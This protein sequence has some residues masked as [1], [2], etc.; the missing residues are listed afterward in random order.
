MRLE[1]KNMQHYLAQCT[2]CM[3]VDRWNR[4]YFALLW[5]CRKRTRSI[6]KLCCVWILKALQM[7]QKRVRQRNAMNAGCMRRKVP[8]C[9]PRQFWLLSPG[10]RGSPFRW[11]TRRFYARARCLRIAELCET[12]E[13]SRNPA[14]IEPGKT[15]NATGKRASRALQRYT[16]WSNSNSSF[17]RH[18]A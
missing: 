2:Q 6:V 18:F 1:G 16:G 13:T 7:T 12:S 15:E 4:R 9:V 10:L 8:T 11:S 14:E 5:I 3:Q 17:L